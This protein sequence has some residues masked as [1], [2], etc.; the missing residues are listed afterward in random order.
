MHVEV[1]PA[2]IADCEALAPRMRYAD[3]LEVKRS[4]G[5]APL[6][7]LVRSYVETNGRST[8]IYFDGEIA[9]VGGIVPVPALGP[10]AAPWLLTSDVVERH[11]VTFFRIAKATIDIWNRD[12]PVLMQ[13]VDEEYVAACRFLRRLGFTLHPPVK[14][15]PSGAPFLPA[16]RSRHV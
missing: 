13:L 12:Y 7:A 11:P 2:T 16:V 15:G 4:A 5:F 6:E 14:H 9:A 1:R 8:A 3:A 10:V